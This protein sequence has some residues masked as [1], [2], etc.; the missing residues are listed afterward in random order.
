MMRA[1]LFESPGSPLKL[2]EV[3]RP[4]P[5]DDQVLLKVRTCA[6]C[7]TD[8]HIF[9]GELKAPKVP[10]ILGHQ[11]VGIV[12]KKGKNANRYPIGT[13]VGVSWL[14]NTCG[15]CFYCKQDQE[16]LC[17]HVQFTGLDHPGGFAEYTT[18]KENFAYPLPD[19]YNDIE[20]APLLCG[21]IIGYRGYEKVRMGKTIG[22]FGFGSAAHILCQL[23]AKEGKNVIAFTRPGDQKTQQFALSL[24]AKAAY[25]SDEVPKDILDAAIIFAADGALFPRALA[26]VRKG[27]MVVCAEITMSDIPSF[28]YSHIAGE[29]HVQTLSNLRRK[30]AEGFLQTAGK[31]KL[32]AHTETFSLENTQEALDSILEGKIKGSAVIVI[33]SV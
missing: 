9:S 32:H 18:V 16:N 10:L 5:A 33:D 23:A 12:E 11:I 30:D 4:Q 8:V 24:G 13:R 15:K 2:T 21:G 27:G 17:E 29:R 1:A 26:A 22:F 14:A 6:V 19:Q 25:G 3:P 7:R 31:L 28:P 20:V